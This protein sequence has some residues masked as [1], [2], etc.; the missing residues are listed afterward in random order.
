MNVVM[1]DSG[2]CK[3]LTGANVRIKENGATALWA[4]APR[5]WKKGGWE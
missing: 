4:V 3:F 2:I 1:N 5:L